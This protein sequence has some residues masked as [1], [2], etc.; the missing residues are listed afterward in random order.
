METELFID[1]N[2][3][4]TCVYRD[5]ITPALKDVGRTANKRACT[6]EPYQYDPSKWSV[7]VTPIIRKLPPLSGYQETGLFGDEIIGVFDTRAEALVVEAE[8]LSRYLTTRHFCV[9]DNATKQFT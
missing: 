2:G 3:R 1:E 4:I 9:W 7:D 5:D 6:V 8:W